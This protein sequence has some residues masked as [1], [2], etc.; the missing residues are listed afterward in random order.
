MASGVDSASNRNG[1][2]ECKER[3][4]RKADNLTD[5]YETTV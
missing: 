1:Y 2:Q 5:T 3:P 4:T